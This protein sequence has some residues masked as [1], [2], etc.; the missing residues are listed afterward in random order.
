MTSLGDSELVFDKTGSLVYR[1]IKWRSPDRMRAN[2]V[3]RYVFEEVAGKLVCTKQTM[4]LS[5]LG[6]SDA[7]KTTTVAT[8]RKVGKYLVP[9]RVIERVVQ[10]LGGGSSAVQEN[11]FVFSNFKFD[12]DVK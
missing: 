6:R 11:E 7:S 8:Y 10:N 3:I 4:S 5:I 1:K 12:D 9:V 2:S